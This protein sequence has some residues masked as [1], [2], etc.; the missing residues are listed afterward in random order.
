MEERGVSVDHSSINP[1]AICFLPLFE[2]LAH[3]HKCSIGSS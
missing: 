3:K 2:K 1:Q